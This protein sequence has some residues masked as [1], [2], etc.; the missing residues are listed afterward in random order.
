MGDVD[1]ETLLE[2]LSM[3]Q[4][5]ERD[6]QL[7]ALEQLCMLLLMSDNVD[8][9][10]ESCPPRTFLPALCK[11][12]LDELAPEN[13]LEVTARAIT[14]YLDVSSECTRR[15]VAIDGA[16]RAICN[17]L[18]VADLESRTS[19]DLA[20]QCIKVLELIC[21]R[22]A[23]AVFEGGGLSCVLAFIR[24]S[25][26]QIHK[27][28]LHS[29]MA[30]V[31]RLCT[32]VEPS[33]ANVQ[34]CVESLS[35]L[36]QH[37]DPLVADGA[38]KCFASV[39]DRFTRK[40]VDPAP[41]AEYGL[42]RELLQRLSNAAGGP[43]ISSSGGGGSAAISSS[44][45]TN[46]S[47]HPES[48][49]SAAQLSSSAPK[50][51]QG[52][53]EA[54]RS[55]Q[56]IATTISL[57]ST[58]CR[59]SPSI[60]HDLLRSNLLEAMER[61]F[62][63]DE[64]CVLD[65][66]RL[67]DLILLLL[68]EGRQALG[69]V[70]GSQGQL[71]PRVRRAD[72]STERTH[73][74]LIDCIRS[75]DT[76]ALIESIESG[77]IDVNCMDDVGQTLLNWASAFGTLEMVEFLCDKGADVNK[78]QRSS[79]LHYAA[80]FGRPGIAKVLLK[81]GANPDLR[82]EDG[83]TPLDKARER[84]DEGHREVASILQSPGEWMMAATRSDVKCGDSG[85][86][87][88]GA[89]GVGEP[90]GDPEMAP[91]YLKFFL[92]TFCKT[93]QSTMLASVRRSSLG[94][95]K[96]MIQYVQ[97]EVL[98][99]LCSSEGLQSYEQSLGTLLVEVI[100]SVLD[101]EIS[102]SWPPLSQPSAAL[103]AYLPPLPP[104]PPPILTVARHSSSS[105]SHSL[106]TKHSCAER[107]SK[108]VQAKRQRRNSSSYII[109]PPPP[110]LPLT[111]PPR[112]TTS[113]RANDSDED[114]DDEW[115]GAAAGSKSN[116]NS[117]DR[118]TTTNPRNR[119]Q[120]N[121]SDLSIADDED[122]HLVVL[123][124]VQELMSKTQNDF[125]D[126][127]ARLGVYTK[128]QALMGEPSFDGSDN[129]DVIKSTSDDAKSAAA[130]ACSSTDASGVVTVTPG[131]PTVTT[132]SGGTASAAVAVEDAK[133]ILHGKAYHWHDW[134]ICRGRDCLYV[135]SDSAALELSNGSNG[136]FRFILDG[137]LATM[138][139]SG[140]PE[141]GSDSTGKEKVSSDPN[142]PNEEN[143]GE[144]LE[145]LQRARAAVRQGTVSQPILSAPSLA[146]IAVG[147]WVLQ[148]Q[149]E[150]QLHINNSEGHQVTILQDE[151]PG[152]IFESNR[153]TKHTFTAETTLGPDFAAGWI[154]TKK[155]KMRCKAE[156]QKYQLHKLARD[157]YNRYFKAAQ[158]IPRG[159]VAK[160]SKIVHQIEIA[161]EEQQSTSKAALISSTT[162][163]ITPPSAGVSWQEKLYNA[164]TELV[165][166]LNEDGVISAYEMYSSGLV[167]ALVAVLS[168]NYWD[169]G[170]N[171][172]KANKYQKQR[173]SIFKKCMYGG[174]LKT[175]KNTAAILVQKLVAVLES[176]EKLP[177]YM[178]DSP[179]G[180]YGL[181][182]L[183]K[184]LSFRLERAACEQTLFDRTG[185]NLKMEPL[186]TVGH[187]N[188]YLLKMV[189]KQ[190]YD[191]E[192][193]SFLYLR[194]MK[195]AKS[196]TMQ[197]RHRH[198][199]DENGL[200]YYIGT[201]GRTLE[202]VNPA[203]YGLVTV[204]S[205][206][207]K[208]LPYGK[209]ED[210]LSRDSVSVNCHTKDNKKSWFAIDLG[211]FILPT[212]YTLRHAR[213]YGRSALRNWLFQMSK[214]GV[215]WVTL[216]THTDDKSL[217]E[218]GSTCTWPIDCPADEQQGY[219]HV[220]IH[221]NGRNASGQTHYLSLSG[222][223]IYGKVMSVCEDM[224]KTA[225]K[226]NEA[227]LRKER[228]Q[229]RSQLKYITDGARVVRG[230]DWHWDDQDGSPPGE[231]T[232]IAE[233]HNG[234]IDVKWDHGM[235][236]SYRMG[237]EGK[238][239][240]KLANVDGLMA[241]GYD[242]HSSGISVTTAGGGANNNQFAST[243]NVQCELADGGST[244]SGK[245]KVYDKSLNVL[246]SR[247]SSSTPS[248]PDATTE[249]RSS[250]ASTEQA[251]SADNLSWKQAVEVITE[252]VLSS[253]RSDLA[254]VGSGGS[255]N[256]LSSSVVT[257]ST[258]TTGNNQEVSVT[259]HSSLSERGN[260]IPD[261]SQINSSTS[262]L[263]SDLATITENL[264]LSDGSAKQSGT[265]TASSA[266]GQQFVSNI[267][268]TGVPVLMGSSS[269]S[270]SSS[271][272][273]ENNKTN[274][275]NETNNKINLTSGSGASSVASGSS[276]SSGKAG[277]SYLQ[278]R[279]DMMGKM[280]EGVDML[281]NNTNNFL[282]SE[283]LTQS[284]LL[285]SV[286]IAFPPIP[287]ANATTGSSSSTT[288]TTIPGSASYGSSI[289]VASTST[290]TNPAASSGTG[291]K[292]PTDKFDVK[293]NNTAT[294]NTFKKV[295]NEAKQIGAEQ[296]PAPPAPASSMGGRD[297]TN[298]LKNNIVV[299]G[300]TETTVLGGGGG[301]GSSQDDP[302]AM[303][304]LMGSVS[305]SDGVNVVPVVAPSPNSMSVSVPNL[306]SSGTGANNHSH[307]ASHRTSSH[308]HHHHNHPD[309]ASQTLANDAQPPPPGLLET[310]AAIARRRTSGSGSNS[311][312]NANNN[313]ENN[314]AAS[315][316]SSSSSSSSQQ[317]T[318]A[319]PIN[320]QL[321]SSGAGALVGGGGGGVLQNNSNFFPRGPNSVT[322]L[323][324]LALSSHTGLLSTAQS[325][326]SLFSSS[327]NNNAAAGQGAGNNN[328]ANN[329]VGVGQVNP[330]NPAL[331]MSLTSTSS[332][333]EQVS[334]ED[335]LEQ[336]RA[337]T[338][339]GDLEDDEDIED[340]NDDDENED[341]YEEVG[342]TLLQ[343]MVSRNLLS[344]MEERTFENR[345]P[346][347]GKRKSWDDEFV[348]KRQFSALI[349]AFDPRPGKTNVNQ[350]SDL[351]IPAPGSNS[352]TDP[353]EQPQSSS[354]GRGA[355]PE[356]GSGQS[357]TAISSLP[358]PTL[359]LILRGPNINGVN[360]VEVDLTQSDWTIFRAVQELMLQTTMPKQDKFRKI[361]QPTYTII[362]REA[363]PGSSSSLLG[364]GGK[365]DFSS[366]EEGRATPI[367]SMYSQRSHG[368]TLS[369]SSPVP[370]TPSLSGG[371]G[372]GGTGASSG[373]ALSSAPG[374]GGNQQQQQQYC[375]VEDVLQLLSQLNSINQSLAATPTNNDKNLMPDVESHYLSPDVF[376][377]KKITNKLQQQIQDPL[378]LSSGSL[379]K[380]CEEYNQTCPF[381]FPFETRQLYF[382]CTAFGASRS[383]VWL[384]S[385]RDVSLERQ[386]APGLSPRHADQQEFR[387][388]RLKH[389]RV[390][391][392]RGENLLD[393]AQQ[394]MKVHCNRKSVLEVEFVGE[395][396]TGLGPT[397]EFYALV[398]A[399]LQRSD[400][401][402][403]LCDDEEPK[404]IEDE[405]DLGE[406]SKP[407]GYYVRRST[408]LFP[409][410]LPQDSD[411]SEDV[412]G[413]FWFLGVFLAKVLQDNRLVDLPLSNSFLQLL[414]HSRSM[415]RGA[416]SQTGSL[417]GKSGVSDDIMMSSILSED[418]DRDRDLLVDSYQSKMAMA[419]DGAWY[420]G[421]LTQENLQEI[422][423]I[424]YQF[425][426]ELQ[427]LVQ[428]KQAIEQNDA[429]S[430]EEKLQ[431]ISELKLNTKTG[432]VALEDLALTF[433][434]LPSSRNYGYASAD[435]LPNGANIDVTIN[436][437]EE[438][439]N[440]TV[441]FCLQEG[442][443]KQLAAFH[444]GFCEV[445]A[446]NKLAAFTPDEI[447][448][449]LCGEQNPEWTREDIMTYTEPKLG[450]T[451]ES[452][453][454]LRF[455]NVLMG[456]NGSER[457][458]FLQFTTGCS[459]LPP[460][461]LANLHPRLTVVR[462]VDAGEG[463]YPSVN[464][465]VHYLKLPD[466][467][468]EQILRERLLTA[469]KEKGFHLN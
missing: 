210:I 117:S 339:L 321:I 56:S 383:I 102:Y 50:S 328:N 182:I 266:G 343:V 148:S 336:C 4:G 337:P 396:G 351:D 176:I 410:P 370:G 38:L 109:P 305:G 170:M 94:L 244:A 261:L 195:E 241:G 331:T 144:F 437:V 365:E 469:T 24:D 239:D 459:S 214:D 271:S 85:D 77:G 173:L 184:K 442:I 399:E 166:L 204:T 259:V 19:R 8:R 247:K 162:Q 233:I 393:W 178:Y 189:A 434:Y 103:P 158:A 201:N 276:A 53:M 43:Q 47:T 17:R 425:L 415:A 312:S 400:L 181:Q 213:G 180:S 414:S 75:K 445:F 63:G 248:L 467:P 54:G 316:P 196:G 55:S 406:G 453:G 234:W 368:S 26:S 279:L 296:P 92:P 20:E 392:P 58:L 465:C 380:W 448:K 160:L 291:A 294:A 252:N 249:N 2:W 452:P 34:T 141:N 203:Q 362:Y 413:Y 323:V 440:L 309:S 420:D 287:P 22:E 373:G 377:S 171:R 250:V 232:V 301:G 135:W 228:R 46:S 209:L 382:S 255:S 73:R 418:S 40:G 229:I 3:G 256:D 402:M 217:A 82:D 381:L 320:N 159:A 308:H 298:N 197:F 288:A 76:E 357:S 429:L 88:G 438:Y 304:C 457:K 80:C 268:G 87:T 93:F 107:L 243:A 240:L 341:E 9:C 280:R 67:A 385:Q 411:I 1:P 96:K 130:A 112:G 202:W 126:H 78:G 142:V 329:M 120:S 35:T 127:F 432:C 398:A 169:L 146:R 60:T 100:A 454:F 427:E 451:K 446:L 290:G 265:A 263:V 221:Q 164:L 89:G 353:T 86:E 273:E 283:L 422:D 334:L 154:N 192:R 306:T 430:S 335:F 468:N 439:C 340:E 254:T 299:V 168:P 177:V 188:K 408:G 200:I 101:N 128:V 444:R 15:I 106:L 318:A 145:K 219:R 44:L 238:Y 242:L 16:I 333:S 179:G 441:A 253:A 326:P 349:P 91:V 198:D 379:P 33:G 163:Q 118:T 322:S 140:S 431:Q 302:N 275:I 37:E 460:G 52:A 122:G 369:P 332:D 132:A 423:P 11:I 153:G 346:T 466:Y 218:P 70:G 99:K 211:I 62:K 28:T 138:Y 30:V 191:M 230:V 278:T 367:I 375:S 404:L 435:L 129:N 433:T 235:R 190:W 389:E 152:F 282:S 48:S 458:A 344:F 45:G 350:T 384:Q 314:N 105:V 74:Q 227:K 149:K 147:N 29:A 286:K 270:S 65:C 172:T 212:A 372:A 27:D 6:M 285:S 97:P 71:A 143:R 403:W 307:N 185:R 72:S 64:R 157:L 395:E 110:L 464:T 292:T 226:E 374:T 36:L 394:V 421:I 193:S 462:K 313:N 436:N 310:F 284:N 125:L 51:A 31:S 257:S 281:R 131:A 139:S 165:H 59:G 183:T 223:E 342:N 360:D 366:G 355:L 13:V 409:A 324:K 258:A 376:M 61:A 155:K 338:L 12:F 246:T 121:W 315:H 114:A 327:S 124:I 251:T 325:Y 295:L 134:S 455:V 42:V 136:W 156:A 220:R 419:S 83:K 10:F 69:R 150:H 412:S 303:D 388:G 25:G 39:A 356:P 187:L 405:I 207:G 108:F 424:R 115:A 450:Y 352:A 461:G 416:T 363:S 5:D 345:L 260:N 311:N 449:M 267:S 206:E 79:S 237:A 378:V 32:K 390:K 23:G 90:R 361:W 428:Q 18:E 225:A 205:S 216:L 174:E 133:E 104:P 57:L 137:K 81:H 364:G 68:F 300:S 371:G 297:A 319:V 289:F 236:N 98:S 215:S 397:L 443:A 199:F 116:N 95:I 293:F 224:D 7:I 21:T 272:T 277:L 113:A 123:T 456:M 222:F 387:V 317:T 84:P 194:K 151:L 14:Y 175:G 245:K 359:S 330:L 386:R 208:Q 401:G 41:L 463:S 119:T 111:P 269:S 447:R 66:M 417:L 231:G 186:A 354:S 274:N 347:A 407:V 161:L 167:Q 49:P 358:Q 262:M 391:V 426:R 348:L 264:S